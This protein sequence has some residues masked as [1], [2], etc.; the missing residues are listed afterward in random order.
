MFVGTN[1]VICSSQVDPKK[2]DYIQPVPDVALI[3]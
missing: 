2:Q 3:I 1:I